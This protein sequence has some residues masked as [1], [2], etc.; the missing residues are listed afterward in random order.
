M[1]IARAQEIISRFNQHK[2]LVVGDILL[3][4]YINGVVDRINPEAPVPI[5]KVIGE[6]QET[7]G[8]GNV[9]KNLSSLGAQTALVSVVGDDDMAREVDQ[10]AAREGYEPILIRDKSRS[11][12]RKQRYLVGEHHLLRVD[13]ENTANIQGAIQD[14]VIAAIR[15]KF[16][17]DL[18]AVI[19]SDYA[20]GVVNQSVAEMILDEAG[21]NNILVGADIKPSRAQYFTGAT[22]VAPNIKEAHEFLGLNH[23]EQSI[24]PGELARMV[25]MKMCADVY[26]TLGKNGIYVYCGGQDGHH[27]PQENM[28]E[29]ADESGAGDTATALLMLSLL[30]GANEQEASQLANAGAA[31]VVTKVGSVAV[32]PEEIINMLARREQL[33]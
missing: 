22:F 8:A 7:G 24:E 18:A 9:A 16:Q 11:T 1:N 32:K 4:H 19:V 26:L 17:G 2:I 28:I 31:V 3:D 6:R 29:V 15:Q 27:I 20:K 14:Q 21:Q 5:L 33:T 13:Y 30:S 23:L 25:Y 12:I 10:A